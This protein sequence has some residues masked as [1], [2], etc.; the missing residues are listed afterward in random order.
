MKT[1]AFG[2][3]VL[4]SAAFASAQPPPSNEDRQTDTVFESASKTV[5]I[6]RAHRDHE[7]T[8]TV[9]EDDFVTVEVVNFSGRIDVAFNS[10]YDDSQRITATIGRQESWHA[11][12]GREITLNVREGTIYFITNDR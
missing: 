1:L 2:L 7:V 10:F 12:G 3:F 8:F 9:P 4:F 6:L 11:I 5:R